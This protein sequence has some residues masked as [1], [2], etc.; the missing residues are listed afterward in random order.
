VLA[1]DEANDIISP[2]TTIQ[3]FARNSAALANFQRSIASFDISTPI[4]FF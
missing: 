3:N 2:W 4:T 1:P